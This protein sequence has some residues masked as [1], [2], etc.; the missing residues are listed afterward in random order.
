MSYSAEISRPNPALMGFLIDQSGSMS[1]SMSGGNKSKSEETADAL[2]KILSSLITKNQDKNEILDRFEIFVLGYGGNGVVSPIDSI[3]IGEMPVPISRLNKSAKYE[4]RTQKRIKKEPDGAGGLIEKEYDAEIKFQ[5][6]AKPDS[7]GGTPMG[8][9]F[10]S[11]YG[12]IQN[13]VNSHPNSYPPILINI[14]DGEYNGED[15]T[16][17]V[18]DIKNLSTSDGSTLVFNIHISSD[19]SGSPAI[20]FPDDSFQ[21]P[22]SFAD[23]LFR[24]S[25]HLTPAI[26]EYAQKMDR[27]VK[28]NARGFA[29]NANLVDLIEF[30]DI[31]TRIN[32]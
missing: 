9:A 32:R 27:N 25:S 18:Q 30:L 26:I 12:I 21:P 19:T 28:T 7:S 2:N 17:I 6:W 11:S 3:D 1:D 14:T 4:T 8:E 10:R 22:D 15:P 20:A 5:V 24:M 29:F 13:W 16:P 23:T 31:G